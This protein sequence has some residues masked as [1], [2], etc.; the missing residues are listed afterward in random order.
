MNNLQDWQSSVGEMVKWE[1]HIRK[2]GEVYFKIIKGGK[3]FNVELLPNDAT[4]LLNPLFEK[5]GEWFDDHQKII[6]DEFKDVNEGI[7]LWLQDKYQITPTLKAFSK[8]FMLNRLNPAM[9]RIDFSANKETGEIK[10]QVKIHFDFTTLLESYTPAV[11]KN[12]LVE[13]CQ[14]EKMEL[15]NIDRSLSEAKQVKQEIEK[16]RTAAIAET[17]ELFKGKYQY[18]PDYE[19]LS[20]ELNRK[21]DDYGIKHEIDLNSNYIKTGRTKEREKEI[22]G[23]LDTCQREKG[24]IIVNEGNVVS[25]C[26]PPS[27]ALNY[28]I[29]SFWEL[30]HLS[31]LESF[32]QLSREPEQ[33]SMMQVV[34]ANELFADLEIKD[35]RKFEKLEIEIAKIKDYT[36]KT[37]VKI[38]DTDITLQGLEYEEAV[39]NSYSTQV[40]EAYPSKGMVFNHVPNLNEKYRRLLAESIADLESLKKIIK[41]RIEAKKKHA[42]L[43]QNQIPPARPIDGLHSTKPSQ[44]VIALYY[45]YLQETKCIHYFENHEDKKMAAIRD[46]AKEWGV[47]EK[48]FQRYYNRIHLYDSNRI[49][50]DQIK[51]IQEVIPML[52]EYPKAQKLANEELKK[53]EE[54]R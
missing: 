43:E 41:A 17:I 54:K 52:A 22:H 24:K 39:I 21:F 1:L 49:A 11:I 42:Q 44:A 12:D 30:F 50:V 34:H 3:N 31:Q 37:K 15:E 28:C 38:A 16:L 5:Y 10:Q 36:T 7:V 26:K 40:I 53:A 4:P 35:W 9:I 46:V 13:F 25:N 32:N 51:N 47:S 19:T 14:W 29:Y 27:M 45:H 2:D 48:N 20:N 33:K 6:A 8:W 23:Y 18:E